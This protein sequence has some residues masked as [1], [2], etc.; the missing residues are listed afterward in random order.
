MKE[1]LGREFEIREKINEEKDP[2]NLGESSRLPMRMS[3]CVA[4]TK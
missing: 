1:S 4:E 2:F 3:K